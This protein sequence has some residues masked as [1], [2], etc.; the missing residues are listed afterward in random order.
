[1]NLSS[2]R[3]SEH[4]NEPIQDFLHEI[5]CSLALCLITFHCKNNEFRLSVQTFM[6]ESPNCMFYN[7]LFVFLNSF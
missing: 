4:E 7:A 1:M 2:N 5:F 6:R 3:L